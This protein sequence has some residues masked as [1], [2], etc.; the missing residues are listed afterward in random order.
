[1]INTIFK[2]KEMTT[3]EKKK[4][5]TDL[6]KEK[7]RRKLFEKCKQIK[8]SK[9]DYEKQWG[10]LFSFEDTECCNVKTKTCFCAF[11]TKQ[12]NLENNFLEA[13]VESKETNLFNM[14]QRFNSG[15]N[16]EKLMNLL[17]N[18]SKGIIRGNLI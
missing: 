1:M 18:T 7:F 16:V 11:C 13:N 3:V 2:I 9:S 15:I 10:N 12:H 8:D 14:I 6:I 5:P 4:K 17:K